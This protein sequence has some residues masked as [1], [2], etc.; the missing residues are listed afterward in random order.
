MRLTACGCGTGRLERIERSWWMRVLFPSRRLYYCSVCRTT[1]LI[2]KV[3]PAR[4]VVMPP[5]AGDGAM[6][7]G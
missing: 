2:R 3:V 7:Q 6:R 5:A 4:E 1:R